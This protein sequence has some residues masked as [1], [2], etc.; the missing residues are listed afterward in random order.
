MD[1]RPRIYRD[2]SGDWFAFWELN[3]WRP[4]GMSGVQRILLTEIDAYCRLMGIERRADRRLFLKRI[5]IMD[6]AFIEAATK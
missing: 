4:E 6:R 3:A 2:L 1:K 5:S